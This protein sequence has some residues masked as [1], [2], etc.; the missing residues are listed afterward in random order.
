MPHPLLIHDG[1]TGREL[2]RRGAPFAQPQWSVLALMQRPSAVADMHRAYIEAG[3]DIITTN[4]YALVPFHL[5]EDDFRTQGDKLAASP[6]NWRSRLSG[7]AAKN[8]ASPPH[9]HHHLAPAAPTCLTPRRPRL[10]PAHLLTG[11]LSMPTCGWP[12]PKAAPPKSVPCMR[13]RHAI[14]PSGPPSP[15]TT[16]TL[17]NR[18]VCTVV[19]ASPTLLP[20]SLTSAPPPTPPLPKPGVP[21]EPI[22]SAVVAAS[23]PN[24]LLPSPPGATAKPSPN[25]R[26]IRKKS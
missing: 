8:C 4:S 25:N 1:G 15:S 6:E 12:K 9:C 13:W 5:S 14:T 18:H 10:S 19:K 22:S 20:P 17:P 26:N 23:A 11:R 2:L 24:I 21:P 7:T 16:S 3:T